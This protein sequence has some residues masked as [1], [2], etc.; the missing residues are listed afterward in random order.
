MGKLRACAAATGLR[1]HDILALFL[2]CFRW[3][4]RRQQ[5]RKRQTA[6]KPGSVR[7][8]RRGATIPLGRA[9]LRDSRDQPGRR[10]GNAPASQMEAKPPSAA[11]R[12]Y[13]VLL[14]VGFALPPLSP[15][16]RCALT[17]PFHPCRRTGRSLRG[18][19]LFSVALSLRSPSPAVSRHRIL[20]EPGLSSTG[21]QPPA[22]AARPSGGAWVRPGRPRVKAGAAGVRSPPAGP[23]HVPPAVG[24]EPHRQAC[25]ADTRTVYNRQI[26]DHDRFNF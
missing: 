26:Y 16:A 5:M 11:G 13:S 12:P 19:G 10:G 17:A 9:L 6:C 25:H 18:G 2:K 14:P 24:I 22:A 4:R 7:A 3:P 23:G 8:L 20:V 1:P 21:V 15:A